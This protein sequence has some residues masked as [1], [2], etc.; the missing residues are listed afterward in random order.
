MAY[1]PDDPYARKARQERYLARSVYKLKEMDGLFRKGQRILDLGAAPGSW[2]QYVSEC[3]GSRG[4]LLVIDLKPVRLDLPNAVF[5]AAD[6]YEA[7]WP[8]VAEAAGVPPPFDGVISD[9]APA[10]SGVRNTDQ[11]RSAALCEFALYLAANR[12]ALRPGGFFVAKMFEGP[13]TAAFR[14]LLEQGFSKTRLIRPKS[15][16]K[17][18]TEVFF[19]GQGFSGKP[20]F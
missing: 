7:A 16:R 15:T 1:N 3:I 19:V 6:L 4:A 8:S 12:E 18:S 17:T 13:D 20:A 5:V 14:A 2:A 11:A 9:M 10:T